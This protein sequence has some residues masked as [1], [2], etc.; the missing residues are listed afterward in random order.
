MT[1]Q[2]LNRRP[3]APPGRRVLVRSLLIT[4]VLI[5]PALVLRFGGVHPNP[6][7]SLLSYGAAV[8]AASFLLAWAAERHP[9]N[10]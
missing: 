2:L 10:N 8:V 6:V 4:A 9:D 5:V 3:A 7:V 1:P